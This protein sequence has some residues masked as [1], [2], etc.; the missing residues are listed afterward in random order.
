[1][2]VRKRDER[3]PSDIKVIVS[4]EQPASLAH[5]DYSVQGAKLALR[6]AFPG[7]EKYYENRDYDMIK[8]VINN[9]SLGGPGF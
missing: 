4:H 9:P 8:Y 1:L 5:S 6:D 3:F 2:Q 7:Q